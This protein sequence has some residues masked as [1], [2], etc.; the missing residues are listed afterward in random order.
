MVQMVRLLVDFHKEM[1]YRLELHG[2][3]LAQDSEICFKPEPQNP[4]LGLV[5]D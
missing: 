2:V 1:C 3:I 4:F 5:L